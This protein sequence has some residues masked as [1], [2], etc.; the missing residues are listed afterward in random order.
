MKRNIIFLSIL[1]TFSLSAQ[2]II[3]TPIDQQI[4]SS[5]FNGNWG[6]SDLL[7]GLQLEKQ[8]NS[9]KYNFFKAYNYFYTRYLG[10][11]N[12]YSR[13]ETIRQVKMYSWKAVQIG[14]ELEVNLENNFYLGSAYSILARVNV[15]E[16]NLWDAY[17]NASKSENYFEEV[18]KENSNITDAYLNLGIFKYFPAVTVTGFNSFLAWFG[19]MSGDREIGIGEIKKA[20]EGGSLFKD[21]ANYALALMYGFRENDLTIA[22][23]YWKALSEKYPDNNNFLQQTNRTYIAKLV[24]EKGVDFLTN[25]F[26][27]LDSLYNITDPGILNMLGYSLVNQERFDEALIVFEVNIRKYPDI[28]NGYDS[29]A[30]YYMTI[31]DNKNAIKFYKI[32][33][34]K[35]KTDT[36]INDQFRERLEE[37]IRNNLKELGSNIDV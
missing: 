32:A 29:L 7:I 26:E 18:I 23:R 24:D 11:N 28:A 30:E 27:N 34:N 4:T 14:E 17:W 16:Q 36:T 1:L 8:P 25:E 19:G 9:V 12:P 10:N 31:G 6:Q 5:L 22:Y 21:E 35:L 3:Q 37:G 20:A 15:M 33:F 2:S 13:D